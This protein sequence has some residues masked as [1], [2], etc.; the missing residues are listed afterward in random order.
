MSLASN[1]ARRSGSARYYARL[2]VPID[3][4]AILKK[5]ELWKS[6]GTSDPKVA[7]EK[8][9]PVLM[10][11]RAEFADLRK[12]RVPTEA[13]LQGAVWNEYEGEVQ[14]DQVARQALPSAADVA[15][16]TA[17]LVKD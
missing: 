1:I 10:Q 4:R 17:Q 2:A 7:R 16:A 12:R 6:L 15:A 5:N 14:R 9:L 11:W 8:V 13:D 3:L